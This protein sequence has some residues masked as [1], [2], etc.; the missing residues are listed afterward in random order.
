MKGLILIT[1]LLACPLTA[2]AQ[3]TG[4]APPSNATAAP[5]SPGNTGVEAP[6][7]PR[8]VTVP[9]RGSLPAAGGSAQSAAP[10][11]QNDCT[12]DPA[13][14]SEPVKPTGST[15]PGLPTQSK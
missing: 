13:A 10:G 5:A 6:G 3:T 7:S 1:A 12:K 11:M 8:D 4:T 15:P 14:C 2:M 9:E